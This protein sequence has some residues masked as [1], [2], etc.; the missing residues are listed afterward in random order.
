M[1]C[2]LIACHKF[3]G[4]ISAALSYPFLATSREEK[5]RSTGSFSQTVAGN[6]AYQVPFDVKSIMKEVKAGH[7]SG[8]FYNACAQPLVIKM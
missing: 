1:S 4:S 6:R 5:G 8:E 2:K 3:Q 7:G